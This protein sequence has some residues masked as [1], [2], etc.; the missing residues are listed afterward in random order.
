MR[1]DRLRA[2]RERAGMTREE[3]AEKVGK[4]YVTVLKAWCRRRD[5]TP[6]VFMQELYQR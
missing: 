1:G 6:P 3:L 5:L 4:S 2:A